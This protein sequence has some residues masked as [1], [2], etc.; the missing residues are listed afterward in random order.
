MDYLIC[1]YIADNEINTEEASNFLLE[2]L[3]NYMIP[4]LY[5]KMK[6]FPLTPN[7]KLDR[8]N[9]PKIELQKTKSKIVGPKIKNKAKNGFYNTNNDIKKKEKNQKKVK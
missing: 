6:K 7:G 1:Y 3:P 2:D 8:K 4:A 5:H 9:L